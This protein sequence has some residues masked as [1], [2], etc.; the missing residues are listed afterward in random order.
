MDFKKPDSYKNTSSSSFMKTKQEV[1]H[2][3]I[4]NLIILFNN[5]MESLIFA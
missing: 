3:T 2:T 4:E 1:E 5:F